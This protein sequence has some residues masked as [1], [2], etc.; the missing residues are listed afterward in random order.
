MLGTVHQR[1]LVRVRVK[2]LLSKHVA[3]LQ[4]S[5]EKLERLAP[6]VLKSPR[7]ATTVARSV[8]SLA[9][10]LS[11][12]RKLPPLEPVLNVEEDPELPV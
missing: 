6:L 7:I 9:I 4:L 2:L 1:Q 3:M 8:T 12:A 5:L 10:A 11:L